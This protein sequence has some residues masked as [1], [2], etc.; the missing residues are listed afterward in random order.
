MYPRNEMAQT[1]FNQS[2]VD[3]ASYHPVPDGRFYT[4]ANFFTLQERSEAGEFSD[5]NR[6]EERKT[7]QNI[8][9]QVVPL[10][11]HYPKSHVTSQALNH[12]SQKPIQVGYTD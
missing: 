9:N 4:K 1:L 3:R 8:Q 7:I 6:S 10:P 5:D 11:M 2:S 12:S